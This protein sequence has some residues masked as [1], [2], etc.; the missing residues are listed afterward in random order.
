MVSDPVTG[1][2]PYAAR[3]QA[4]A[5][6]AAARASCA[7]TTSRRSTSTSTAT[8][9]TRSA[10]W[11][12]RWSCASRDEQVVLPHEDVIPAIVADRLAMMAASRGQPRADPAGLRR[13]RR[14]RRRDRPA[15]ERRA[16]RRRLAPRRHVPPAVGDHR[17]E[18]TWRRSGRHLAPHQALIADGHHRYATYLQLR[19]RHRAI[20]DGQGPWDRG[21]ALL[22]DQSQCPLQ[23]GPI[24]RSI[25]ELTLADLTAPPGLRDLRRRARSA[26]HPE[27]PDDARRV[28]GHRRPRPATSSGSTGSATLRSATP[29]CCTSGCCPAWAVDR[30]PGR[31]PPHRR[32][33]RPQRAAGRRRRRAAAPDHASPR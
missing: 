25:A 10:D 33:D 16:P 4:A 26:T 1:D 24:H 13:R 28:R 7:P 11:S 21:L 5:P 8:A 6:V 27:P 31:L 3:R 14:H 9:S 18:P 20:G 30:G 19:K 23:L 2:D 12:A 17:R 22:I 29:S 15:R 32:A